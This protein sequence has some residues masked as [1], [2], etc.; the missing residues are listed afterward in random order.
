ML[1]ILVGSAGLNR[2]PW[3]RMQSAAATLHHYLAPGLYSDGG[4]HEKTR[5]G[6]SMV[7]PLELC[8]NPRSQYGTHERKNTNKKPW[9]FPTTVREKRIAVEV[10]ETVSEALQLGPCYSPVLKRCGFQI[11]KVKMS[12]DLRVAHVLWTA[13]PGM[14]SSAEKAA[15][16]KVQHL[17]TLVFKRLNLPFSPVIRF[18]EDKASQEMLDLEDA[19]AKIKEEEGED[20]KL[21]ESEDEDQKSRESEREDFEMF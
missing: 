5:G 18:Q 12:S 13:L 17:R 7:M 9:H 20:Q 10:L 2:A 8:W 19:F 11:L 16:S 6:D 14:Q 15:I 1:K 21:K 4:F 3:R